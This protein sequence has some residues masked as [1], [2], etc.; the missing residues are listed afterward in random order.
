VEHHH[1]H[2]V[3]L[4]QEEHPLATTHQHLNVQAQL[5]ILAAQVLIAQRHLLAQILVANQKLC[6]QK[7][8]TDKLQQT[9]MR[10][11]SNART[12]QILPI[13]QT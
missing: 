12:E 1:L 11:I 13:E 3:V 9:V 8:K 4:H 5:I 10:K 6:L 7:H 2:L